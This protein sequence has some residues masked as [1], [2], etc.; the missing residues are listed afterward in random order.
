VRRGIVALAAASASVLV[1]ACLPAREGP[2]GLIG[3]EPVAVGGADVRMLVLHDRRVALADGSG[4]LWLVDVA[5]AD[6]RTRHQTSIPLGRRLDAGDEARAVAPCLAASRDGHLVAVAEGD[7]QVHLV[8]PMLEEVTTRLPVRARAPLRAPITALALDAAGEHLATGHADGALSVWE[9]ASGALGG[10][11]PG[12][13]LQ[14][15]VRALWV[16]TGTS[17][18]AVGA[19]GEVVRWSPGRPLPEPVLGPADGE[20]EAIDLRGEVLARVVGGALEVW[21]LREKARLS[22]F[23]PAAPGPLRVALGPGADLIAVA[24]SAGQAEQA[25]VEVWRREG[26]TRLTSFEG[27]RR[28]V[29]ALGFGASG[30]RVF[31]LGRD[32]RL[33]AW[34]LE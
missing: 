26:G 21:S 33:R 29:L 5:I 17:V 27:H 8:T 24:G 23:T 14:G 2:E 30:R 15:P 4:A 7:L 18:H 31:S 13:A 11:L 6:R 16:G 9:L 1:A 3:S 32:G 12:G 34:N 22:A 28:G 19:R 10:A 25:E 20:P